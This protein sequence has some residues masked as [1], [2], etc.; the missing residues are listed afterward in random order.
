MVVN[1][2]NS[3]KSSYFEKKIE[4]YI[5]RKAIYKKMIKN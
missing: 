1:K 2:K 4:K 3:K 5:E